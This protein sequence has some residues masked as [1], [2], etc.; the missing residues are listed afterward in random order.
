MCMQVFQ[1]SHVIATYC[2]LHSREWLFEEL[3]ARL[4]TH[5]QQTD[6]T[7]VFDTGFIIW[8]ERAV[9]V[10]KPIPQM[11]SH[12]KNYHSHFEKLLGEFAVLQP[13]SIQLFWSWCDNDVW[14]HSEQADQ[15][16]WQ[17]VKLW[18]HH[19]RYKEEIFKA[20]EQSAHL[21]CLW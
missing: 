13:P 6:P 10:S 20:E 8:R 11:C 15:K 19:R 17:K 9:K 21:I 7:F 16:M 14:M 12:N 1:S 5:W 18:K 2:C 4:D 3:G